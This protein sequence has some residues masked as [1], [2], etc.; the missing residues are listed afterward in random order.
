[1]KE[2]LTAAE[3]F[4]LLGYKQYPVEDW[5]AILK[6]EVYDLEPFGLLNCND[7]FS[8]F[9]LYLDLCGVVWVEHPHSPG[10]HYPIGAPYYTQGLPEEFC[11][12]FGPVGLLYSTRFGRFIQIRRLPGSVQSS[13]LRLYL[14]LDARNSVRKSRV[15]FLSERNR[16]GVI[17]QDHR[18]NWNDA[19]EALEHHDHLRRLP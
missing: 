12:L 14:E 19:Q 16:S 2:S 5:L 6:G 8:A 9:G 13:Q 3:C 4:E 18:T 7:R 10:S 17:H 1:M 15:H 11:S